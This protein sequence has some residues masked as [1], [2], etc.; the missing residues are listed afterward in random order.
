MAERAQVVL[1]NPLAVALRH[2]TD[3]L[4]RLLDDHGAEVRRVDVIEPSASGGRRRRWLYEYVRAVRRLT[5][6]GRSAIVIQTWPVLGYLDYAI[7]R[8][9]LKPAHMLIVIHDARPLVRSVGY[10]RLARWAASLPLV[11]AVAIVHS[12]AALRAVRSDA[13]LSDVVQLPHP[14]IEPERREHRGAAPVAIRVLGQYK[15]DRDLQA[16]E[17]LAVEGSPSW[18]YEAIG[19]GWPP[20][21]GWKVDDRFLEEHELD[22]LVRTSAVVVIPYVRFFQSGVAFRALQ[23]GAPVVGPRDSSL[24]ELLGA[25]SDWLV[26]EGRWAEAVRA[27]LDASAQDVHRVAMSAYEDMRGK[28]GAWLQDAQLRAGVRA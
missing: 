5:K 28:W 20:V 16:M 10:G 9:V 12:K 4:Q 11:R 1:L 26:D 14:M 6:V 2:Y 23:A 21:K 8:L 25:D 13:R 24:T 15:P 18:R 17:R 22:E 19:R 7:A 3:G 27:A